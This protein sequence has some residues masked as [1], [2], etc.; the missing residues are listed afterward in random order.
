MLIARKSRT[1][2]VEVLGLP[3]L[4]REMREAVRSREFERAAPNVLPLEASIARL[5]N[6]Y[7]QSIERFDGAVD[8]ELAQRPLEPLA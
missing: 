5:R 6:R 1:I 8:A 7:R 4:D 2:W 3:Q